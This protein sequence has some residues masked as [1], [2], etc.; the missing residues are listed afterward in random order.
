MN[1]YLRRCHFRQDYII[2]QLA[3]EDDPKFCDTLEPGLEGPHPCIPCGT[4]KVTLNVPSPLYKRKHSLHWFYKSIGFKMPRLL[5]VP[6]RE[7]VLIHAGNTKNDTLGCILVGKNDQVGVVHQSLRTF[8]SLYTKL[9]QS[10][11]DIYLH[12]I[13]TPISKCA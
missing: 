12:I 3:F 1:L 7:G 13:E 5:D 11:E 6:G 2:G 10:H 8:I 4:Y 9:L